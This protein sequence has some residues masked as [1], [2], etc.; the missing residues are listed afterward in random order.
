[1]SKLSARDI[2]VFVA[3]ALAYLGFDSLLIGA[4]GLIRSR[5]DIALTGLIVG[6]VALALGVAIIAG[7]KRALLWVQIFLWLALI[8]DIVSICVFVFRK[9][10]ISLNLAHMS[11]Y[12]ATSSLLELSALLLL[13]AWS[14]FQADSRQRDA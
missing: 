2:Q 7:S 9:F 6:V 11:L 10:G 1:M 14:R 8:Q 12:R 13:I 3:G 4:D 5:A